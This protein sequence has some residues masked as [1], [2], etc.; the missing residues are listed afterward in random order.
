VSEGLEGCPS[1][2]GLS[3]LENSEVLLFPNP[4]V[5]HL[6]VVGSRANAEG[7]IH[8][9]T[10]RMVW[11]GTVGQGRWTLDVGAWARGYYVLNMRS[12]EGHRSFTFVLIE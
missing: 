12:A 2:N 5:D 9:A 7:T 11:S 1:V 3:D 4:A 8:D 6:D 10:G